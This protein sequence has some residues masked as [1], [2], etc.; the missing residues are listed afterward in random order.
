[1]AIAIKHIWFDIAG[2][3]IKH[4][5]AYHKAHNVLRYQT[6][7][8]A[9]HKPYDDSIIEEFETLYKQYGSNSAV[10]R[11]LGLDSDYWMN[12]SS[13]LIETDFAEP[14]PSIYITLE[15]L[16]DIV[17]ISVMSNLKLLKIQRILIG[18]NINEKWFTHILSGDEVKERKPALD[19][20]YKIIELS[21]LPAK[22][23]FY[24]GDRIDVDIK[25][26]KKVG[27]KTGLV[28]DKSDEAD[29]SFR[30]FEEILTLF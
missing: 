25:P 7:A 9:I 24:V 13:H 20:F 15:K 17:P 14:D 19:A 12:Q 16:K 11:S 10:F 5:E 26:A 22:N 23:I 3:L 18:S 8:E 6:Y 28:W 2:T 29:Y 27:M 21:N 30:R 1:M 4:T